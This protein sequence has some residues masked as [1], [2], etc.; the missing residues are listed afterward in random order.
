MIYN[1]NKNKRSFKNNAVVFLFA[2]FALFIF[3]FTEA[4]AAPASEGIFESDTIDF[5]RT[6][7]PSNISWTAISSSAD[8]SHV[9]SLGVCTINTGVGCAVKFQIAVSSVPFPGTWDYRGPNE[10]QAN[11]YF[12]SDIGNE[13]VPA[14]LQGKRYLRYKI[15]LNSE[16][17]FATPMVSSVNIGYEEY[18][19]ATLTSSP[20]NTTDASAL[21]TSVSWIAA[22]PTGASV[23]V[24]A[25]SVRDN[26]GNPDDWTLYGSGWC[27]FA[28]C[29]GSTY[30]TVSDNGA[31]LPSSH[32]LRKDYDDQWLQY[33]II[34]ET[35]GATYAEVSEVKLQYV[36]F[37]TAK[38]GFYVSLPLDAG[39]IS[40]FSTV[41]Y[42]TTTPGVSTVK[43]DLRSGNTDTP[44]L[45]W[46]DDAGWVENSNWPSS[47]TVFDVANNG[48]ISDLSGNQHFQY[49]IRFHSDVA[50]EIPSLNDITINYLGVGTGPYELVSTPFNSENDT[51]AITGISWTQNLNGGTVGFQ[52]R[53]APDNGGNPDWASGS[54]WRGPT[55]GGDPTGVSSYYTASDGSQEI[56]NDQ[57]DIVNN[58]WFQ[59]KALLT[60]KPNEA[61]YP[62]V[63]NII[64]NY[65]YGGNSPIISQSAYRFFENQPSTAVLNALAPQDTPIFVP[66]TRPEFR[67]RILLHDAL[68]LLPKKDFKLQYSEKFGI[69]DTS[70]IGENYQDVTDTSLIAYNIANM[71][72]TDD[73][74]V[75]LT[76]GVGA[77]ANPGHFGH[78]L[79]VIK[80][81]Y[82]ESAT[83][84]TPY[85]SNDI[86]DIPPGHDG[87]WDFALTNN[88]A[89]ENKGY[90]F[91]VVKSSGSTLN[92]YTKIPEISTG[93]GIDTSVVDNNVRGWAWSDNIGWISFSCNNLVVGSCVNQYGVH[94]VTQ[95]NIDDSGL[96]G[97]IGFDYSIYEPGAL[98][99]YAWSDKVG[100]I[101][102]F[103]EDPVSLE[104]INSDN[105]LLQSDDP[106]FGTTHIAK[107]DLNDGSIVGWARAL[108]GVD[109]AWGGWIKLNPDSV[110]PG[111]NVNLKSGNGGSSL[112]GFAWGGEVLGWISFNNNT[113]PY[114]VKLADSVPV[115]V[116]LGASFPDKYINNR[117][118]VF[119][120]EYIKENIFDMTE[121]SIV[122][123]KQSD[124]AF[125]ARYSDALPLSPDTIRGV[126]YP[127]GDLYCFDTNDVLML[128]PSLER[129]VTYDW[130]VS[131]KNTL[132]N[133]SI[134]STNSLYSFFV[135]AVKYPLVDFGWTPRII[136]P[137]KDVTL[138]IENL[139]FGPDTGYVPGKPIC[140]DYIGNE[141]VE[142]DCV[143]GRDKFEWIFPTLG[144]DTITSGDVLDKE[145]VVQ[146]S[147]SGKLTV[148]LKMLGEG[149][150]D[151]P[152]NWT[153]TH[154]KE[155]SV[156]IPVP[157]FQEQR[158]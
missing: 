52:I 120:F 64:V 93:S 50:T 125:I 32:P 3:S 58:Q 151:I 154:Y 74:R 62:E 146:F 131:V 31:V 49:R 118:P 101:S 25:R 113:T 156:I 21:L 26:A 91:R 43:V 27:G 6:V 35:E 130:A 44:L 103:R 119:D 80:Q 90:C 60:P 135:D 96:P 29:S 115:V 126:T 67:L 10:L 128:C 39:A 37:E 158:P 12:T 106:F 48:D 95:K 57:S 72:P 47:K 134:P 147:K 18:N 7:N 98:I 86:A 136:T 20:Y 59:Y 2:F 140:Y 116:A 83:I 105:A 138:N 55:S 81:T 133:E 51:N 88:G 122:I 45:E 87:M 111:K 76:D 54:D 121:F 108:S 38:D 104:N 97:Y 19:N 15:S 110:D 89:P 155:V 109:E 8:W 92:Q 137:D 68:F 117:D 112:E 36:M 107:V 71:G 142:R 28:D 79:N 34:L 124:G 150:T 143:L 42:N 56:N 157:E 139:D 66:T 1:K 73:G 94:M 11:D 132:G 40:N 102:F 46:P 84:T 41:S 69:C 65:T 70:F 30:F 22:V 23:K 9:E 127:S 148:G 13:S 141:D 63:S 24:Q 129:D 85:F 149:F 17:D 78:I 4:N 100:W 145:I 61:S 152:Q 5:G 14:I 114:S 77:D 53:T 153:P 123:R 75:A 99:G 33:K 82:I 144:T 16:N